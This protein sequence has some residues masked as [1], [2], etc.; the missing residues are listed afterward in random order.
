MVKSQIQNEIA[1]FHRAQKRKSAESDDIDPI[2]TNEKKTKLESVELNGSDDIDPIITNEKKKKIES[3]ELN[4]DDGDEC[5]GTLSFQKDFYHIHADTAERSIEAVE[6]FY[7]KHNITLK[8]KGRKH[9]KPLL[10]FHELGFLKKYMAACKE[11]TKP[12]PIQSCCWPIIASGKDI[13]GIAE[14]GSGKTLAFVIPSLVHIAKRVKRE[15]RRKNGPFMLIV[16]PTRELAMQSQNVLE[17]AGKNVGIRSVALYGGVSKEGQRRNLCQGVEVIVATPGRLIDL[18]Q[19]EYVDLSEVSYLVLDEADRMLD[20]GFE[21]DIRAIIACTNVNRQTCL[22][23]ATWPESVCN[24]AN[25]FLTKPIRVT[26][27]SED[28]AAG[29][30]ITQCVEVIDD[31][32]RLHRLGQ[33]L[34]N[35]HSTRKNRIIIFVLYKKEAARIEW[36]L[37]QKGWNCVSIHGD[38]SQDMRSRAVEDF[39]RG[40]IPLLIATD[41]AARGLDIPGVDYVINYSFP[42]TVEDYVHRIGRTGRAGKSGTAHTFFQQCDKARAGELV[43]VLKEAGQTVPE[44]MNQFDLNVKR[45]AHKLYGDFGPKD[46]GLPMKEATRIVFDE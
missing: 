21:R 30:N 42:L 10:E 46:Y 12:T 36:K 40:N 2:I 41:V 3:V 11:F 32:A 45:K 25:E 31:Q 38:K 14:T 5:L 29:T 16:A 6:K 7:K 1:K 22:F 19:E 28:L 13:V 23:S 39:K 18:M 37:Q 4:G 9:F 15:G 34:T 20:Q 44:E 8:G 26:I 17:V 24:I 33:L 27:G 35:Y 43:R